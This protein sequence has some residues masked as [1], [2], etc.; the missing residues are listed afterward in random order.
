[1]KIT[2]G[3]TVCNEVDE[4]E[5]LLQHLIP[6]IDDNDE[7]LVLVDKSNTTQEI[8]ELLEYESNEKLRV[9]YAELNSDFAAFK[10]NLIVHA[11]GDYLFQIDADEYPNNALILNLK[12]ILQHN[13]DVD[14]FYVPRVNRVH[15]IQDYHIKQWGWSKDNF[16]RI[17]FPDYQM[18]ILKLK[19]DIFWKNAVHEVFTNFKSISHLPCND[20]SFCLYHYKHITKQ[21]SQ[22]Q[23]Y[24]SMILKNKS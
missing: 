19:Q 14:V 2:Y 21:E 1:M 3:I 7:V 4:L 24:Q 18:R 8:Y 13:S 23:K 6:L 16:E 20:E 9:I 10:N 17:N 11:T 12:E 22:N 15:G 5:V